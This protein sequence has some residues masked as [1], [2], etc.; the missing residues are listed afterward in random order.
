MYSIENSFLRVSIAAKGAELQSIKDIRNGREYMW[1]GNPAFW[2]KRSPVLFPIVGELKRNTYYFGGQAYQLPR[3]GFAR[4]MVFELH[5]ATEN[6]LSFLLQ[7]D[8]LTLK[9]YP[10]E[11]KFYIDYSI[12]NNSLTVAYRVLNTGKKTMYFSVGGHPAFRVPLFDEDT[13]SDYRLEFEETENTGKWPVTGDGL[14]EDSAISFLNNSNCISLRKDL[15]YKDAIVLKHLKSKRVKLLSAK[16]GKGFQFDFSGFPYLGI[17]A[18]R[19]ADF[20][21]IEP[22][23]GVADSISSN[24]LLINKEGINELHP[25]AIFRRHWDFTLID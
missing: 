22:W 12:N 2:A 4:D 17:W 19:D 16:D 18:A 13:Y 8:A 10:F 14:L 9:S 15:F 24:Q 3:H 5:A 11:F 20:V 25:G 6:S 7:S 21:C 1:N 23:C